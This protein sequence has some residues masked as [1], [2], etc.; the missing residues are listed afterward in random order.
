MAVSVIVAMGCSK[1]GRSDLSLE[2]GFIGSENCESC[3]GPHRPS[4][5]WGTQYQDWLNSLHG[6]A[7]NNTPSDATVVADS[8]SNGV[9]D[10]R[11][12]MDLGIS[13]GW[14]DFTAAGGALG[15]F[16][17]VLGYDPGAGAFTI[18]IGTRTFPVEK[19]VGGGRSQQLYLTRMGASLYVLPGRYRTDTRTWSPVLPENWFTWIDGNG[20]GRI[21]SGETVTGLLYGVGETPVTRGRTH[22]S[23]ER[24]CVGC[25]VT[26]LDSVRRNGL[27]EFVAQ[28]REEGVGCEACHG[29][30]RTHAYDLGRGTS[31]RNAIVNPDN[32]SDT[33]YNHVCMSCHT[34]GTSMGR[35]GGD[36]LEYPWKA[37]GG[38]FLP[39][40]DL[41]DSFTPGDK[42][43]EAV[44]ALQG[45]HQHQGYPGSLYGEWL[46]GCRDCHKAHDTSNLALVREVIATPNS[47]DRQ[48]IFT[49]RGGP[50]GSGG[51]MGDATDGVFTDIC[52]VCHT[53][54][55]FF[56]NDGSTPDTGHENGE[57]CT[58]CHTHPSGFAAPES[59]GGIPC[60][61]C[62]ADL[63]SAMSSAASTTYHHFLTDDSAAYPTGT[64]P[65]NCNSC[66]VDHDIFRPDLN[67]AGGRGMNLRTDIA[68][69]P[70]PASGF[71]G[72]DFDGSGSGGIC[73]SCHT[74]TLPKTY[75][76]ADGTTETAPIPFPASTAVQVAAYDSSPHGGTYTVTS[77]YKGTLGNTFEANCSKCHNDTLNPKSSVNAQIGRYTF[78]LHDSG[79]RKLA[80]PLGAPIPP[81]PMTDPSEEGFCFRCHSS[82]SDAV[83]GAAKPA[84]G[85]DWYD[86]TDM[87]AST[88]GIYRVIMTKSYGHP[89]TDTSGVHSK[90]EGTSWGWSPSGNRHVECADCHNSHALGARR[91]LVITGA[92]AQPLAPSNLTAGGPLEGTWGVD[93]PAWSGGWVAPDPATGYVRVDNTTYTWQVCLKC[94]S[95]YAFG[96]APPPGSTDQA[97][98]FNPNNESYHAVIGPSRTVSIPS[99]S[100]VGPWTKDSPMH[101]HDCHSNDAAGQSQG[102]HG[103]SIPGLLAGPFNLSTGLEG[104]GS[105][106]CFKCH[107]F[108]VYG[109]DGTEDPTTTGFS[110]EK[111]LHTEHAGASNEAANRKITC[112]DCHAAI[113]H[114]WRRRAML[115]LTTDPPPY[116]DG[117]ATLV[118]SDAVNWPAPGNWEETDC[119][120]SGCH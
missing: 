19:T 12:G 119:D 66:H 29:M 80:A 110:G 64:S 92:F 78:G 108:G 90:G 5:I 104:T 85:R 59:S 69:A 97:L 22:D 23:W 73:L 14:I 42:T 16:A 95:G 117:N 100:F 9:N 63:F 65:M 82:I 72:T 94:H 1:M 3:H 96:S 46:M 56:R 103:S 49:G 41:A 116:N 44:H 113:P 98:E 15:D 111:N 28:Y 118:P 107:S 38:P 30:G 20:D 11:D 67:P 86:E 93:V 55:V 2:P 114:G 84:A 47:G 112:V 34:R 26:G 83:G 45:T 40:E 51:L 106:L 18:T 21:S 7:R 17:P 36:S 74:Q 76:P 57:V 27:G 87:R 89:V 68:V 99:I 4:V 50:P 58:D 79:L 6:Q 109:K 91:D 62:H 31:P 48:V 32:L 71:S 54:T 120:G 60:A 24:S 43:V 61:R 75:I 33:G 25:H 8:D 13:P 10:F 102:P 88:E 77:A 81:A 115:T 37:E 52:E 39:G 105:H 35:V 53:Q 70:T 101:C